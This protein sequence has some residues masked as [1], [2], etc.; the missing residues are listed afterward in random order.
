MSAMVLLALA[1][2]IFLHLEF[3]CFS[4]LPLTP[5]ASAQTPVPNRKVMRREAKVM[6]G[7][8]DTIFAQVKKGVGVGEIEELILAAYEATKAASSGK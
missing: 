2:C 5:M 1:S 6:R 8:G 7:E 3:R 4:H